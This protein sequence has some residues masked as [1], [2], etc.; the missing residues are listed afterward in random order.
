[1]I[2]RSGIIE[3]HSYFNLR[4]E[5][6]IMPSSYDIIHSKKHEILIGEFNT[7]ELITELNVVANEVLPG[8]GA[9]R[10]STFSYSK[11]RR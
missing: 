5:D 1:M 2:T 8:L 3:S 6:N 11:K 9:I 7:D 4:K 10:M